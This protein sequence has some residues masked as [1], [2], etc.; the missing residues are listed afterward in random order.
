LGDFSYTA[1]LYCHYCHG[2]F[3]DSCSYLFYL[4]TTIPRAS[5]FFNKIKIDKTRQPVSEKKVDMILGE[6]DLLALSVSLSLSLVADIGRRG[7]GERELRASSIC[8]LL[9]SVQIKERR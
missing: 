8:V 3:S 5:F 4:Q 7:W 1:E 2:D 6:G 9:L